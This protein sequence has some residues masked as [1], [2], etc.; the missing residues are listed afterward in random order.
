MGMNIKMY[1]YCRFT[2]HSNK[3]SGVWTAVPVSEPKTYPHT[4]DL[5]AAIMSAKVEDPLN[6]ARKRVR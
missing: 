6:M 4:P 1:F 2:R 5:Q 3:K